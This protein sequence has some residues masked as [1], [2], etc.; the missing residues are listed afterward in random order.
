[1][2]KLTKLE[3][4]RTLAEK[5][6]D[7]IV[8]LAR[9]TTDA[10]EGVE[11]DLTNKMKDYR[12]EIS[13]WDDLAGFDFYRGWFW[14]VAKD[15]QKTSMAPRKGD[16]LIARQDGSFHD[17]MSAGDGAVSYFI[18][19]N[20]VMCGATESAA[21]EAGLV[22]APEA[23]D[24]T[25]Y[26][27]SDGR[28]EV[29]P[30]TAF[31]TNWPAARNINGMSI[32]GS[33]NRFNYGTCPTAG[34]VVDK[35]VECDGYVLAKGSEIT[36]YFDNSNTAHQPRLNVNQTGA[37]Q[38]QFDSAQVPTGCLVGKR[39]Y[40]FRFD[41][42]KYVLIGGNEMLRAHGYP[43]QR[44]RPNTSNA[45]YTRIARI[46]IRGTWFNMP[47]YFKVIRRGAAFPM[48][49]SVMFK[50]TSSTDPALDSFRYQGQYYGAY[51]IKADSGVWDVYV[52]KSEAQDMV[53]VLEYFN[54]VMTPYG[55][56]ER[57]RVEIVGA[58][59]DTMPDGGVEPTVFS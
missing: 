38:I 20:S 4:L 30:D 43:L 16:I 44:L 18:K 2:A 53:C 8:G 6:A 39:S 9:T 51:I 23:G 42:S 47:I 48:E 34:N 13:S 52:K 55:E 27:R 26:L 5:M 57:C 36:V 29:P 10:I 32:N 58:H 40:T 28:W 45:G 19:I 37:Q 49:L 35:I 7:A 31:L 1:M 3:H 59:S 33:A 46:T 11:R 15:M 24:A 56:D 14:V 21:G 54:G 22:P 41:G 25:R 17:G 12:G 50:N